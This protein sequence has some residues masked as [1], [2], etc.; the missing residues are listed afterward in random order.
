YLAT[1]EQLQIVESQ[2]AIET[3]RSTEE[4]PFVQRLREQQAN[5]TALRDREAQQVVGASPG[6]NVLGFQNS[7]RVDL[8]NQLVAAANQVQVLEVR[9]QQVAQARGQFNQRLAGFPAIAGQYN[10]LQRQL[11]NETNTLNG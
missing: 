6:A 10:D 11:E 2:L 1:L 3:A 5:L 7:V 4:S 8:I 9:N